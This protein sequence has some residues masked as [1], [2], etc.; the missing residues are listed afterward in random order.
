MGSCVCSLPLVPV[1]QI[2]Y[3]SR[4][5]WARVV[6]VAGVPQYLYSSFPEQ[7]LVI[8]VCIYISI[9]VVVVIYK[10]KVQEEQIEY[11]P[12]APWSARCVPSGN[13]K[14]N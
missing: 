14:R 6:F 9:V 11:R 5:V 13:R 1:W 10:S 12:R 8:G 4:E 2:G 3:R 7:P